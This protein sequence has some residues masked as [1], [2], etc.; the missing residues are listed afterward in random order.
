MPWRA[1]CVACRLRVLFWRRLPLS[2]CLPRTVSLAGWGKLGNSLE[3]TVGS[4]TI[5]TLMPTY[6]LPPLFSLTIQAISL[7]VVE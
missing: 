4:S 1:G 7:R 6:A 2:W 5:L 3:L